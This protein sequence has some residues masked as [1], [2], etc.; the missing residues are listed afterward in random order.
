[1]IVHAD[2]GYEIGSWLTADT[3]PDTYFIDDETELSAKILALYPYY[4]LDIVDGV[5]IDVVPRDKTPE[6]EAAENAPVPKTIETLEAENTALQSRL[7][8]VELA[9]IELFGGV[10]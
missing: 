1:M 4:T 10:A 7:A 3:Y 8:D 6:E 2:G 9:L 5:L